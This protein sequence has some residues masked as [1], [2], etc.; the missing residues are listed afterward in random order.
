M[1]WACEQGAVNFR[2]IDDAG[3]EVG[4]C[5]TRDLGPCAVRVIAD[6]QAL[7]DEACPLDP[8]HPFHRNVESAAGADEA[9]LEVVA[10]SGRVVMRRQINLAPHPRS[11]FALP[12]KPWFR[13]SPLAEARWHE[14]FSPLC[15]WGPWWPPVQSYEKVLKD[16]PASREAKIGL[17]RALLKAYDSALAD[18]PDGGRQTAPADPALASRA[19]GTL[20]EL[21]TAQE[22]ELETLYLLGLARMRCGEDA[23]AADTL[24]QVTARHPAHPLA[25]F[26]LALLAARKQRWDE[27]CEEARAAVAAAPDGTLARQLLA[28]G[29]LHT[30]KAA[31]VEGVLA[32]ALEANPAE[33]G[34]TELLRRAAEATEHTTGARTLAATVERL[35]KIA[36]RQAQAGLAQIADMENGREINPRAVDTL[37]GPPLPGRAP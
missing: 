32:P 18:L 13:R 2:K 35:R 33:V 36:W 20:K 6:G 28:V 29:L 34:T 24:R 12:D 3:L 31:E 22:P 16:D 1:T 7:L 10:G 15:N 30:G 37:S 19:A 17:A 26:N 9:R 27:V 11:Q 21:A 4:V 23:A 14:S 5:P 8:A 25:R